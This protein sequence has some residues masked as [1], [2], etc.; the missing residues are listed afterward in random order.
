MSGALLEAVD[1]EAVEGATTPG[2][3]DDEM[4]GDVYFL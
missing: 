4:D 1:D 2:V 3:P